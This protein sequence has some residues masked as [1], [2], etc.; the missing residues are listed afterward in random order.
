MNELHHSIQFNTDLIALSFTDNF[1]PNVH[2]LSDFVTL[3]SWHS[4]AELVLSSL[5]AAISQTEADSGQD[6]IFTVNDS[7][8]QFAMGAD[9]ALGASASSCQMQNPITKVTELAICQGDLSLVTTNRAQQSSPL[10]TAPPEKAHTVVWEAMRLT[11][12]LSLDSQTK[13]KKEKTQP[14][15]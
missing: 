13:K 3:H 4:L 1:G 6:A 7:I 2:T 9:S 5:T 8:R 10:Q 14:P 15:D 11:F 12:A